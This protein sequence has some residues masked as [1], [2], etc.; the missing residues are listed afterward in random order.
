MESEMDY[1]KLMKEAELKSKEKTR[2]LSNQEI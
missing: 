1:I 2:K